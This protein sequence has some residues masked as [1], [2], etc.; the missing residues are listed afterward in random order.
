M[1]GARPAR[2]PNATARDWLGVIASALG[3]FMAM[4]DMSITNASLPYIQGEIGATGTEGTW[5][6][7]SYLVA[8]TVI[9]PLTA[10]MTRLFGLRRFISSF[11]VLFVVFSM[12]CGVSSTLTEMIIGRVGQ[13]FFGGALIP[14]ALSV[15]AL[16]LPEHQR[17]TGMAIFG[18][19]AVMGP[20]LG[21][22]LGGWLTE[23]VGWYWVFFINLP[24]GVVLLAMIYMGFDH[25]DA[26]MHELVN[27]DWLGIIGLSLFLGTLTVILEEGQRERWFESA[28]IRHLGIAMVIGCVLFI[29]AQFTSSHPLLKFRLLRIRTFLIA[30]IMAVPMGAGWFASLYLLPLF[31]AF[32]AGYNASSIGDVAVYT[33]FGSM[34]AIFLYPL[35]APKV[36]LRILILIG[37]GG[38]VVSSWLDAGLS[39]DSARDQFILTQVLRGFGGSL[40]FFPLNQIAMTGMTE[41][42]IPD[43]SGMFNMARNLGGSIGIALTGVILDWRTN[44]HADTLTESLSANS[45]IA[46]ERVAMLTQGLLPYVG[47]LARARDQA[48]QLIAATIDRQALTMAF[49]DGFWAIMLSCAAL[50]PLVLALPRMKGDMN[51]AAH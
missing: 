29:V 5:I 16:R 2:A 32:I 31:L 37:L 26:D 28:E 14:L 44:F 4:L 24:V 43:A 33:G 18:M 50:I 36:D 38:Y 17:A 45:A 41:R 48:L 3:A 46:Q 20:V 39:P 12:W 15:I 6:A 22:I 1:D 51:M 8:E 34:T 30:S 10:W 13:G 35:V 23:D 7:T 27:A 42:D 47:D 49:G 11:S 40:M 25:E 19:T 9:I 21:P